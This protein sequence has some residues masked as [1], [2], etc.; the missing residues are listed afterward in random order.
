M[1]AE[2]I[3]VG[4][5]GLV[6][7]AAATYGGAY[8]WFGRKLTAAAMRMSKHERARLFAEQQSDQ[9]RRQVEHLQ[10]EL[11]ELRVHVSRGKQRTHV[12]EG[13]QELEDMLLNSGPAKPVTPADPFADTL[14]VVAPN[15]R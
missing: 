2:N 11:A 9:A 5:L 14:L 10:K 15:K 12:V 8:W 1:D 4:L 13:K 3:L 7:G 6:I